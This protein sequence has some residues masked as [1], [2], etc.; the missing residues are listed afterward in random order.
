M[1]KRR[2]KVVVPGSLVL[3]LTLDEQEL[4]DDVVLFALDSLD[5]NSARFIRFVNAHHKEGKRLAWTL[6]E[7]DRV[8]TELSKKVIEASAETTSN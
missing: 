7:V 4:L 6:S 3:R 1:S 8:I 5:K 2:I